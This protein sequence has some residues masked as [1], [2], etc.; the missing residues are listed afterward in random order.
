M[1]QRQ[2][3]VNYVVVGDNTEDGTTITFSGKGIV[4]NADTG[5]IAVIG[6]ATKLVSNTK[7]IT[8]PTT[9]ST[10]S[11]ITR[12]INGV[13]IPSDLSTWTDIMQTSVKCSSVGAL[14]TFAS[15][16]NSLTLVADNAGFV[17]YGD[18]DGNDLII[19][20][21]NFESKTNQHGVKVD[22]GYTSVWYN[23][24]QYI[25]GTDLFN[26]YFTFKSGKNHD[27]I[28]LKDAYQRTENFYVEYLNVSSPAL[29]KKSSGFGSFFGLGTAEEPAQ[30][31]VASQ[32]QPG[33]KV[34][35]FALDKI[36]LSPVQYA[37]SAQ[38]SIQSVFQN[39]RC[40]V[41]GFNAT[42]GIATI[43][44]PSGVEQVP[45][46]FTQV[47]PTVLAVSNLV[48]PVYHS[49]QVPVVDF[50]Q[51]SNIAS[52][53][54]S[55]GKPLGL[56]FNIPIGVTQVYAVQLADNTV[57]GANVTATL[58]PYT[59]V[60]AKFPIYYDTTNPTL[61]YPS[62]NVY[63]IN[64]SVYVLGAS[65]NAT[66]VPFVTESASPSG[67][68]VS[69]SPV[70]NSVGYYSNGVWNYTNVR[71]K[72]TFNPSGTYQYSI[73]SPQ[74]H[75]VNLEDYG[76]WDD[77]SEGSFSLVTDGSDPKPIKNGMLPI[78][79]PDNVT[80]GTVIGT[81][82]IHAVIDVF[83]FDFTV[84]VTYHTLGR[85][86]FYVPGDSNFASTSP[87]SM[88]KKPMGGIFTFGAFTAN[89][90]DTLYAYNV[91]IDSNGNVD[92]VY[93][94]SNLY[95][96]VS[97]QTDN[98]GTVI[99]NSNTIPLTTGIISASTTYPITN[100]FCRL[101]G[102]PGIDLVTGS[103]ASVT[104]PVTA[105]TCFFRVDNALYLLRPADAKSVGFSL[106]RGSSAASSAA[107]T[108]TGSES[109]PSPAP[110]SV[111]PA[112]KRPP[113]TFVPP[114]PSLTPAPVAPKP[115]VKVV[116]AVKIAPKVAPQPAVKP[117]VVP[118]VVPVSAPT[119]APVVP[120]QP[121]PY[122]ASS[123]QKRVKEML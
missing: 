98:L 55:T 77:L 84:T 91:A 100:V 108:P 32:V 36:T 39:F 112:I 9:A 52:V 85:V 58:V 64:G 105:G 31:A 87:G 51:W 107:G 116:Q 44:R 69:L 74:K 57:F 72:P 121:A 41:Q 115:E 109:S 73:Y 68:S 10:D 111:S 21:F 34:V 78:V 119:P 97:Y 48:I 101:N 86:N 80:P 2:A 96:V 12:M 90:G 102:C 93:G 45:V 92:P 23:G 120:K 75:M 7:T 33:S 1:F 40:T 53:N 95:P 82:N 118:V 18:S 13:A 16:S 11:S 19:V 99:V 3:N 38:P 5:D 42:S 20:S 46:T 114:A 25:P 30:A 63:M 37:G 4:V 123:V 29:A 103:N 67:I 35:Q 110:A 89:I 79:V 60:T 71:L 62:Q 27:T 28:T 61:T 15:A 59:E 49:A 76:V 88:R 122:N 94:A 106:S 8:I 66:S 56:T 113:Q 43:S 24:I 14:S 65:S 70:V 26:V 104:V 22:K 17:I 81:Y 47:D 83:E 117:A 54:D 50:T 6:G